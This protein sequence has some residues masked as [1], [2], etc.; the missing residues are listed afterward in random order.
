MAV[1]IPD[2]PSNGQ[3]FTV[4]ART[5]RYNSTT[6]TWEVVGGGGGPVDFVPE[7]LLSGM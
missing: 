3:E 1:N 6:T 5:W 4:G 2:A 7:F